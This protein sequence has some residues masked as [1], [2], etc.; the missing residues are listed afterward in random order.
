MPSPPPGQ[1]IRGPWLLAEHLRQAPWVRQA[2]LLLRRSV[3]EFFADHCQQMAAA[4][5]FHLLFSL[6]P[7]AIAAVGAI[8]LITQ[9][10]HARDAVATVVLKAVPLSSHGRQQ[11]HGLLTSVSGSAGALGLLGI[12]G[13]IWAASGVMAAIRTALNVA[14]DT[15]HKRPFIRGKIIDLALVAS[16]F[17]VTGAAQGIPLLA[18]I[19]RHGVHLPAALRF[20]Q[21]LAGAAATAGV[22]LAASALLFATF[23]FLYR[24]VPA[25]PTRLRDIWPGA[26]TAAAGFEAVQYGFSLYLTYF[27]HYNKIYGS[28][29]AVVAFLF[30]IY[31][32]SAVFLLGAEIAAEYPRARPGTSPRPGPRRPESGQGT[33]GGPS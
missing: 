15:D 14:W 9:N 21:P 6:F 11:L 8:G 5:S 12:I 23:L 32:A 17:L 30:F 16:V 26:L 10:P 4:I 1:R 13:V 31:L 33:P 7:L 2:M 20:L 19:T 29:G 3:H 25:A 22:Y 28:L 18:S 27:G 24:F